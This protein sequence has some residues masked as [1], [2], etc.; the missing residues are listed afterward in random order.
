[1]HD[2]KP[3]DRQTRPHRP[4]YSTKRERMLKRYD[5]EVEG[6]DGKEGRF[7]FYAR[8]RKNSREMRYRVCMHAHVLPFTA[9]AAVW[10]E[11]PALFDAVQVYS[12]ACL[13]ATASIDR[14]LRRLPFVIENWSALSA[15]IGSPLNA[16]AMSIGKS[17]L[18][19][20]QVAEIAS[21]EFTGSSPNVNGKICGATAIADHAWEIKIRWNSPSRITVLAVLAS[22]QQWLRRSGARISYRETMRWWGMIYDELWIA[23]MG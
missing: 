16:Q 4:P 8:R 9:R 17:P 22:R 1:M 20:E 13:A 21:P 11:A 18:R 7:V 5:E 10:L 23:V 15:D 12:P 6:D 2:E 19:M 14:T 3:D